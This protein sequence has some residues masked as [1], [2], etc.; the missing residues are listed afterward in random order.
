M[1]LDPETMSE[2]GGSLRLDRYRTSLGSEREMQVHVAVSLKDSLVTW[3]ACQSFVI[4][5]A[6]TYELAYVAFQESRMCFCLA[7]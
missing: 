7:S 2:W 5:S 6:F 3:P 4:Q 1:R